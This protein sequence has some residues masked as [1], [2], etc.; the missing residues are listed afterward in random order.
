VNLSIRPLY[1]D[2]QS[3]C[4]GVAVELRAAGCGSGREMIPSAI[5]NFCDANSGIRGRMWGGTLGDTSTLGGAVQGSK[6]VGE[7]A[8]DS[9]TML[10]NIGLRLHLRT[11]ESPGR[12]RGCR[13][14]GRG[15]P[16]A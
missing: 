2:W 11:E 12:S 9:R 16:H 5:T 13:H 1:W 15:V 10:S 14:P 7:S 3:D 6:G 8:A 4:D